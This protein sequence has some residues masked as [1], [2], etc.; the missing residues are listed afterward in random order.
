M[1]AEAMYP[2][3]GSGEVELKELPA[4][5]ALTVPGRGEMRADGNGHFM[6]LFRYIKDND[7]PMTTPVETGGD[8]KM[9]FF[10]S[11]TISSAGLKS[12]G[13]VQV[14]EMPPRT[15]VSAGLRG[16][17]SRENLEEGLAR[18]R[19]WLDKRSDWKADGEPYAA[20]WSAPMV[21][22][23]LKRSEIHIPVAPTKE[24]QAMTDTLY[25][26]PLET[27]Q[28]EAVRLG[29][30]RGQVLLIVNTAS[31]C[32]FT[33]QYE[34]LQQLHEK[35]GPR[36]LAVLGFP[37]NDFG[38][39]EPG[40]HEQIVTF[41]QQNY[42]VTFPLFAKAPVTGDAMQPLYRYLTSETT[43]P[44]HAHAVKWNFNKFLIGRDGRVLGYF[45]SM[46]APDDEDLVGAIEKALER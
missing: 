36:G 11:D 14:V 38:G 3:T 17:Y 15:V 8:R 24:M 12:T 31:K 45:G 30:W 27:I 44:D 10:V 39:Q 28:G 37:S 33:G 18:A 1:A 34:G 23:F 41:C 32:G 21:P 19:A 29:D 46:T 9:S 2:K 22:G 5:L 35:Y 6:K 26:I 20:F 42:G 13:Q 7:I 16:S 25:D 40:S 4:R 43:N